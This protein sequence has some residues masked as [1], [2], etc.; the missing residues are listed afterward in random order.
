MLIK[1][2]SF[3]WYITSHG[4]KKFVKMSVRITNY[5]VI[6]SMNN[7]PNIVIFFSDKQIY[8]LKGNWGV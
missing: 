7:K 3:I 6:N 4:L 5:S 2:S 8:D 1:S